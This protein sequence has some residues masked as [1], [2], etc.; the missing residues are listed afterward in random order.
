MIIDQ[1]SKAK[2][3]QHKD[4]D[5]LEKI[6]KQEGTPANP[7]TASHLARFNWGTD[8]PE[9]VEEHLRDELGC[10]QR[11]PDKRFALSADAQGRKNLLIPQAFKNS[12]LVTNKKH[13]IRVNKIEAPPKQFE[14]CARINGVCFEYNKS[15]IRPEVVDDLKALNDLATKNPDA[16]IVIFGHTDKSG[17]EKYNKDLSERRAQS[18][19]AFITNDAD[20]WEKLYND[21]KWGIKSIQAILKDLG[22]EFDPGPVDGIEGPQT[23]TAIKNYQKARGLTVDGIAGPITRKKLFTEYMTGKHDIKVDAG[24]F[25]DPKLEGCGEYNPVVE[26]EDPC[27]TN[28]R[29]TFFFFN[30]DRLPN[31]PCK[32][33]DL[34]PCKKQVSQP[35]PRYKD[36]FH[37]SFFD[38]LAKNCPKESGL[39]AVVKSLALVSVD[40]HFAP[41]KEK[42]DITCRL[43]G[44]AGSEVKLKI[45]SDHYPNNPIYEIKLDATQTSDGEHKFEWDGKANCKDGPLK[46][47]QYVH[48]LFAPYQVVLESTGPASNI[49]AFKVIYGD[50]TLEKGPWVADGSKP[51]EKDEKGWLRYQLN[52]LGYSGGP[53]T[54]DAAETALQKGCL[55]RAIRFYKCS[56]GEFLK[57]CLEDE[58]IRTAVDADPDNKSIY[59]YLDEKPEQFDDLLKKEIKKGSSKRTGYFEAEADFFTK[60]DKVAGFQVPSLYYEK[61]SQ[62][63]AIGENRYDEDA[64]R[65]NDP[66]IP[67][68]VKI[69]LLSKKGEKVES[70]EAIGPAK[71]A[72]R[73]EDPAEQGMDARYKEDV[74]HDPAQP[75]DDKCRLKYMKDVQTWIAANA[76]FSD[77]TALKRNC[78]GDIGGKTDLAAIFLSYQPFTLDQPDKLPRTEAYLDAKSKW[79]ALVGKTGVNFSP[80]KMGGDAYRIIAD[81]DFKD[82][83]NEADLKKW[84]G[85]DANGRNARKAETGELSIWRE[86][87]FAKIVMWPGIPLA[88]FQL[89]RIKVYYDQ[90]YINMKVPQAGDLIDIT[91]VINSGE[92]QDLI[93]NFQPKNLEAQMTAITG[94]DDAER[95]TDDATPDRVRFLFI[96]LWQKFSLTKDCLYGRD[97]PKQEDLKGP[98]YEAALNLLFYDD[99]N[100]FVYRISRPMARLVANKLRPKHPRGH[101]V[102]AFRPHRPVDILKDGADPSKGSHKTGFVARFVSMGL[103]DGI[104]T[105]DL[106]D[107]DRR[108]FVVTH[109]FGHHNFLYHHEAASDTHPTHHD[110]TDHNCT[111]SYNNGVTAFPEGGYN[112]LFCG[113]CN[114]RLRGWKVTGAG[115]PASS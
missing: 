84:H 26:T 57:N 23:K 78:P 46:D 64:R 20:A 115:I 34:A 72:W 96:P 103:T 25:M 53:F 60:K 97:V 74:R 30:K 83:P 102:V 21:E 1:R 31:L 47:A 14:A 42:L 13:T 10:Y 71:V 73:V 85:A 68:L 51:E 52:E 90:C 107:G 62:F 110:T 75:S 48:P 101:L 113:K 82:L 79:K 2:K 77:G 29:V 104:V 44:Y 99:T 93:R 95:I 17:P 114:L 11:N 7:L 91:S 24:R 86:D 76:K 16:K 69:T 59:D 98:A 67:I 70:P 66:F 87:S 109:E 5:T 15:F 33:G 12:G 100:G 38:S 43:L 50:L 49:L 19:Y 89:D 3:Y 40:D 80:S 105:Y 6:A 63:N 35:L 41:G 81:L 8:D 22:G 36:S 54:N 27:E 32:I 58:T 61:K 56:N 112:P 94:A 4:G 106:G 39:P 55:E 65:F 45:T 9:M 28:R 88:D 111:M 37:C 108:G 18:T 92:Y